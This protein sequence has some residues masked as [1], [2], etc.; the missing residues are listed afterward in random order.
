[1]KKSA[2]F[3][4]L[5][6]IC[7][8]AFSYELNTLIDSPTAGIL[9]KG[10]AEI[11]AKLYKDNGLVLGTKVGLFPRF[12]IGVNYGAEEIVGNKNPRWHER[13]EFNCKIRFLDETAQLPAAVIGYD[14]QGHGKYH[15]E[16]KR[17]DIKS[18]GA[19]LA[20]SK[21][22]FFLGN[23]GFHLGANYS[24]E[25]KDKDAGINLFAGADKSLGDMI[26][27]CAE[28]D[29]AWNDNKG[30][31]ENV[32]MLGVGF[33]NASLNIHFTDY[34]VLKISFYDLL[35]NRQDTEGC[36]RTLTLLYFMT[37]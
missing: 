22:Y 5:I 29:T 30:T 26:V 6:L 14:S 28:Y 17:Y 33:L 24:L 9:Q 4:I 10:E 13:V 25:N 2:V 3:A 20:A 31:D 11:S 1:M 37:F 15:P 35:Q 36:D 8:Y 16:D 12:M 23:L 21:N 7:S 32:E 34:L 27:L 19:Y 18:K